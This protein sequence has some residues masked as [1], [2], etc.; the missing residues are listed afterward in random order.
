MLLGFSRWSCI[1]HKNH[2]PGADTSESDLGTLVLEGWAVVSCQEVIVMR[3][4]CRILMNLVDVD[5]LVV[6]EILAGVLIEK[7]NVWCRDVNAVP[8]DWI[9]PIKTVALA[10]GARTNACYNPNNTLHSTSPLYTLWHSLILIGN[11]GTRLDMMWMVRQ[12][13]QI[14]T[15]NV[16]GL[17]IRLHAGTVKHHKASSTGQRLTRLGL[18]QTAK[19]FGTAGLQSCWCGNQKFLCSAIGCVFRFCISV[20]KGGVHACRVLRFFPLRIH[21]HRRLGG[22]AIC[23]SKLSICRN[24]SEPFTKIRLSKAVW[25]IMRIYEVCWQPTAWR[26]FM[27]IPLLASRFADQDGRRWGCEAGMGLLC[28]GALG[29]WVA[30]LPWGQA[31]GLQGSLCPIP[32]VLMAKVG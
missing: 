19:S 32:R 10:H 4:T 5:N 31:P 8:S 25:S 12:H 17:D 15:V 18:Q 1:N 23:L 20:I 13:T 14:E 3:W 30:E 6:T 24:M 28:R 2:E 11:D 27:T 26:L 21:T 29:P 22:P 9:K 16:L 7:R